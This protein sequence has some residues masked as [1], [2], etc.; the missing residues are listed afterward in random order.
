MKIPV[1]SDMT[2]PVDHYIGSSVSVKTK[3]NGRT[4][5]MQEGQ[6][7]EWQK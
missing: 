2:L 6:G 5:Y 4:Y 3:L 7:R 1:C